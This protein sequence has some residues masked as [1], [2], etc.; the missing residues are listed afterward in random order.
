[1]TIPDYIS[2]V[3][4]YRV[5]QWDATG[6]RSL[7]G[8]KWFAHQPLSAVCKADVCGS[9]A[10][11]SKATH[12]R[13]ELPSFGCTCGVYAARTMEH[14]RQCGYRK[15]GVHGEV[16]LWGTLVEH[17]RGWRAQFAYPKVLFLAA[18]TIPFSLS[19]INSRLKTLT[20]FG[21]DVFLLRDHERVA[22]WKNGS[23]F[24]GAGLDYLIRLR[25]EHYVRRQ[26]ERTLTKGD[27]VAV[28]GHGIAVVE[29]VDGKEVQVVLGNKL[30]LRIARKEIVVNE[31]NNRWECEATKA[32]GYQVC[33]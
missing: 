6:L 3:V 7:N 30:V 5:W 33:E 31:Q 2:P 9:I 29:Q 1:M 28:L 24:D 20:E 16:Y 10:G 8:E 23:G 17:E 15:L 27:R 32:R 14:L 11:L 13:A 26:R 22:L 18:D 19:E 4:G 25:K 12:N 21:T